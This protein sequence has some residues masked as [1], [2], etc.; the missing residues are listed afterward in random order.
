MKKQ[1]LFSFLFLLAAPSFAGDTARVLFIGNSYT[2][3]NDLPQ[4]LTYVAASAGDVVITDVNAIGGAT[5]QMHTTNP[6]T[7]AKIAQGNW[8]YVVLQE[9]SQIPSFPDAQIELDMYP[10]AKKLDSLVRAA[11]PCAET[12]FYMTW[13]RKNGDASNC[14]NFP[15]VCTYS[16][17]DSLLRLRYQIMADTNDAIVS[18]VGA[19]W[20]NLRN[21]ALA[22]ELYDAD[23]SHPSLAGSY[24]AACTFY[25]TI[26][27]KDPTNITD[28][29]GVPAPNGVFIRAAV[30]EVVFDSL[31]YW[32][33]G[34]YTPPIWCGSG[35]GVGSLVRADDL[36]I[37][38]VHGSIHIIS[39]RTLPSGSNIIVRNMEGR[40]VAQNQLNN[41]T[42]DITLY[43][44]ELTAGIYTVDISAP[45]GYRQV[46]KF[47]L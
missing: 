15:P 33:I 41:A 18:P 21:N 39:S 46:R 32:K 27:R 26:F 23:E 2:Y 3:V 47:L 7:L 20:R 45:G 14:A 40:M 36:K 37:H 34:T 16:G 19:V 9:Q 24:A 17:M 29:V 13:G 22:I 28:N 10:Y 42:T 11:S 25:T 31:A 35:T 44:P 43:L 1:L 38:A 30:K 4:L 12:I 5:F 6:T 8:D